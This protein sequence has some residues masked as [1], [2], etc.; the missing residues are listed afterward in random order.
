MVFLGSVSG[1]RGLIVVDNSYLSFSSRLIDTAWGS[2]FWPLPDKSFCISFTFSSVKWNIFIISSKYVI[3]NLN[4][5]ITIFPI[6]RRDIR[7]NPLVSV[8]IVVSVVVVILI[9]HPISHIFTLSIVVSIVLTLVYLTLALII[10][11]KTSGVG[12]KTPRL[13]I[14]EVSILLVI[15]FPNRWWI[16]S[17][18]IHNVTFLEPPLTFLNRWWIPYDCHRL[19]YSV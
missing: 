17:Q 1:W 7:T 5:H 15:T 14:Y 4:Y 10:K 6:L 19:I 12:L 2:I 3:L 11:I 18:I 9:V 8:A 16:P 13:I